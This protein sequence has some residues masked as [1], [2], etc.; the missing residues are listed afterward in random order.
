[1]QSSPISRRRFTR[2]RMGWAS[3]DLSRLSLLFIEFCES[4]LP[5]ISG[6]P[7]LDV[8]AAFGAASLAA[9]NAGARVIANDLDES[10]LH[11]LDQ[12]VPADLRARLT[13][14]PGRF[15]REAHFEPE[16]LAA[17]HASSV[18]HFLTGN[19]L[20]EGMAAVARWLVPGGKLFVQAAT[21]Y[22]EPFR[23]FIPEYERRLEEG[24]RWPGWIPKVGAFSTHRQ[25]S[26][27]PR[28]MHL[29]DDRIL[30]R[31]AEEAGLI[32]EQ[33]FLYRRH[34]FPASLALDGRES[35]GLIARRA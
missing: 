19:Q 2:N 4:G 12:R 5:R 31:S 7:V 16:T 29:L 18:L 6:A 27:M 30:G 15:P 23:A 9:L 35:V 11:E 17:V 34:D 14:K 33:T 13:L 3:E 10:H 32:V 26:Q 21:P 8:G 22:Q 1:M 25:L 20:Q 24:Q 28:S